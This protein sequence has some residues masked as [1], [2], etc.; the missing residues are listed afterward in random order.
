MPATLSLGRAEEHRAPGAL[1]Q[2]SRARRSPSVGPLAG[3]GR[4]PSGADAVFS[5]PGQRGGP[6]GAPRRVA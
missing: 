3:A 2:A 5:G 4:E 6:G 1:P